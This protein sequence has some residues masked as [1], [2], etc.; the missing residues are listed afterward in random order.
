VAREE[1]ASEPARDA[2]EI[3]GVG[4]RHGARNAPLAPA[5]QA[6]IEPEES[7]MNPSKMKIVYVIAERTGKSY[8]N[9][10]GVAFV[11]NDG[12]INVKLDA[13]PVSGEL[14]IRDYVAKEDGVSAFGRASSGQDTLADIA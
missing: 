2:C 8:W 13:V 11:N 9:R 5:Q 3:S 7:A 1:T 10:I 6:G 4:L 12:S 14:Q